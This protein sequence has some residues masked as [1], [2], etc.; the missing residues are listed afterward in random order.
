MALFSL[1]EKSPNGLKERNALAWIA[2]TSEGV[3]NPVVPDA[4]ADELHVGIVWE[5]PEGLFLELLLIV[6]E[7]SPFHPLG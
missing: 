7:C 3:F 1:S 4:G 6:L 5:E 2:A